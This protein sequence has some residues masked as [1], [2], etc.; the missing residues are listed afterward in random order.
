MNKSV[1]DFRYNDDND[2]IE[3]IY[4]NCEEL[5]NY[6]Q[7]RMESRSRVWSKSSNCWVIT[8]DVIEKIAAVGSPY[9]DEIK[10]FSLPPHLQ[11]KVKKFIAQKSK[12]KDRKESDHSVLYL[13]EE[14]P[15][16]LIKAAY[17]AL[18]GHYHPDKE[19]GNKEKFLAVSEAYKRI[20]TS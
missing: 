18:A 11:K 14:A 20:T 15:P 9:F 19:T 16:F 17:K 7:S 5:D 8:P 3:I 4:K 1:L 2:T 10:Y 6:I 13:L 12:T